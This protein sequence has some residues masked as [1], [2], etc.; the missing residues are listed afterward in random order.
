MQNR[1]ERVSRELGGLAMKCL[2]RLRCTCFP[3]IALSCSKIVLSFCDHDQVRTCRLDLFFLVAR[4][5]QLKYTLHL[6]RS[7]QKSRCND[8]ILAL[9]G[10]RT[11]V[12]R[13]SLCDI[14]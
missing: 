3:N 13:S 11:L 2:I 10:P 9:F 12:F 5:L 1:V 8:G 6:H 7:L 14:T 4:Q